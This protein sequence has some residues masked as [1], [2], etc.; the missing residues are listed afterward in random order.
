MENR[1][2]FE[3]EKASARLDVSK[4][5]F[6]FTTLNIYENTILQELNIVLSGYFFS[7]LA[8][9]RKLSYYCPRPRFID[10]LFRRRKKVIFDFKAK[11]LLLNPPKK[12]NTVRI[13]EIN[14]T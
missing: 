8:D 11:D 7:N 2:I 9:E 13:Y 6:S 5:L 10:W 1:I 12:E 14:E 3:K 4:E